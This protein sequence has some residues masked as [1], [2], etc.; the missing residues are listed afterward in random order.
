MQV[1]HPAVTGAQLG[2]CQLFT[3]LTVQG[4]HFPN[5]PRAQSGHYPGDLSAGTGEEFGQLSGQ[6]TQ[7]HPSGDGGEEF[8]RVADR[9]RLAV[10]GSNAQGHP[11]PSGQREGDIQSGHG[12]DGNDAIEDSR[13]ADESLIQPPPISRERPPQSDSDLGVRFHNDWDEAVRHTGPGAGTDR[14]GLYARFPPGVLQ[15]GEEFPPPHRVCLVGRHD[16]QQAGSPQRRRNLVVR[17]A[18]TRSGIQEKDD[19]VGFSAVRRA[20]SARYIPP[21]SPK[22]GCHREEGA[23]LP[24]GTL[25]AV[26]ETAVEGPT[27]Y[28]TPPAPQT[29]PRKQG[30]NGALSTKNCPR[31]PRAGAAPRKARGQR[32]APTPSRPVLQSSLYCNCSQLSTAQIGFAVVHRISLIACR[33]GVSPGAIPGSRRGGAAI[34]RTNAGRIPTPTTP[35]FA[36]DGTPTVATV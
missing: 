8:L 17:L 3:G 2:W 12:L 26:P 31:P 19:H 5:G 18:D 21:T 6:E 23:E 20:I 33:K 16:H 34:G 9:E 27:P 30:Q 4:G 13:T 14:N 22:L 28:S 36:R 25:W 35:I 29:Q 10:D 7:P 1:A 24:L 32:Q 11:H 15:D